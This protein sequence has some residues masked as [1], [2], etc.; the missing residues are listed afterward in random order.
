VAVLPLSFPRR[1]Q[2]LKL[3]RGHGLR[4]VERGRGDEVAAALS[5]IAGF[6]NMGVSEPH[7]SAS[8]PS[9]GAIA[10]AEPP[11]VIDDSDD[12]WAL[13]RFRE[14]KLF[15]PEGQRTFLRAIAVKPR[16]LFCAWDVHVDLKDALRAR[17][18]ELWVYG[19]GFVGNA[20]DDD[21]ILATDPLVQAPIDAGAAGWYL[22]VPA[23][24]LAVVV[25]LASRGERVAQSNVTILP[26]GKSAPPGPLWVASLPP[27]IDRKR[28]RGGRLL[29]GELPAGATLETRGD[30][31]GI[32]LDADGTG[33]AL[34]SSGGRPAWP[35][36]PSSSSLPS[37]GQALS[38]T[39]H[40][41][42]HATSEPA[43][44]GPT[45]KAP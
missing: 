6:F 2:L 12:P 9:S 19:L 40:A 15:L 28:L 43:P 7:S 20:P 4:E 45:K 32:A 5:R 1:L 39:P 3:L 18:A 42:S 16:V 31:V 36:L 22:D 38:F 24:R 23:E 29:R 44:I 35:P 25:V 26:P 34:P 13:P 30:S 21:A 27:S 41:T 37:S 17:G 8:L 14:P 11:P 10:P 33:A